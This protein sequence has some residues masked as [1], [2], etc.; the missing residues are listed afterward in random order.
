LASRRILQKA[1]YRAKILAKQD[2]IAKF[3]AEVS[4]M[5]DVLVKLQERMDPKL[6]EE[7]PEEFAEFKDFEKY[8][9]DATKMLNENA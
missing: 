5:R 7:F 4:G 3:T 2:K 8:V 1:E 6:W 9:E